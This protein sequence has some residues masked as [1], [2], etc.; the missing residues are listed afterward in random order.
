MTVPL[1]LV[2]LFSVGPAV[3]VAG[4]GPLYSL[5]GP[6]TYAKPRAS[7]LKRRRA[8]ARVEARFQRQAIIPGN[9][10]KRVGPFYVQGKHASDLEYT[11]WI[12]LTQG[13]AWPEESIEFQVS[14]IGGRNPG[15]A[16]LDFVVWAPS[17]PIVIEPN[18]DVWH[19]ATEAQRQRDKLRWAQ[20]EAAWGGK[21]QYVVLGQGDLTPDSVAFNNLLRL[22]GRG[23]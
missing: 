11:V 7:G 13:L 17:G 6:V 3:P 21:V 5:G 18:G 10:E 1:Y 23:G 20:I 12:V 9:T 22:V 14:A 19:I 8:P 4:P 15:G 16:M 2:T